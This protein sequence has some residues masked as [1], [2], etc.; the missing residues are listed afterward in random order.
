[1][2]AGQREN[3]FSLGCVQRS[4][5]PCGC[6]WTLSSD[7]LWWWNFSQRVW[8]MLLSQAIRPCYICLHSFPPVLS[9]IWS[10]EKESVANTQSKVVHV[11]DRTVISKKLPDAFSSSELLISSRKRRESTW[12]RMWHPH[13]FS[14][15]YFFSTS[16]FWMVSKRLSCSLIQILRCFQ[17][18]WRVHHS[19]LV[20]R[21][22]NV[23]AICCY[24]VICKMFGV[25]T[26]SKKSVQM[27]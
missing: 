24:S 5:P 19:P 17:K 15:C 7:D 18:G 2:T 8:S 26:D 20:M 11:P 13:L 10:K 23:H 14:F 3:Y 22:E 9:F 25:K 4:L 16:I 12:R 1:M 6:P 27:N 21:N